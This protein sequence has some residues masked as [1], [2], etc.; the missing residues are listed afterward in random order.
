M[1]NAIDKKVLKE[2]ADLEGLP[3]GAYNIR[4]NGT[5]PHMPPEAARSTY[6]Y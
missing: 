3:K 6:S 4:K 5:R 2:V 1:L